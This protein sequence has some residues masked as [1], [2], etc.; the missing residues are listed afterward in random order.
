[1]NG[2]TAL[3]TGGAAGLGLACAT[4][5]ARHGARIIICDLPSS[6]G[7][8]IVENWSSIVINKDSS[9]VYSY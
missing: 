8:E 7:K 3:I 4:R 2:L 9:T 1:M 6:K 5:F